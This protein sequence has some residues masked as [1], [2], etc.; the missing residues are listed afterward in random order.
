M[1]MFGDFPFNLALFGLLMYNDTC[2]GWVLEHPE[3]DF[4][5]QRI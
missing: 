1:V 2:F 4:P 3:I 5:S